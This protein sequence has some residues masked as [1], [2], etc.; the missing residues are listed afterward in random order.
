MPPN[1]SPPENFPH[2]GGTGRPY[3]RVMTITKSLLSAA[4]LAALLI[5]PPAFAA[6]VQMDGK[7]PMYPHGKLDPKEASLTAD[8]IAR[9]VPLVLLTA[10][11]V[12]T[13]DGWY[14]AHVA[15]ACTRQTANGGVKFACPDGS[16]MVY[17]HDGQTQVALIP[18]IAGVPGM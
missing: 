13:V 16:I 9:G 4:A 17:A 3:N 14:A 5:A 7:L 15:K 12:A 2:A 8:A 10:D 6:D 1:P 11:S 18:P